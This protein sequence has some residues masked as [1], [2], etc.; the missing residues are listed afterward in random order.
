MAAAKIPN[1]RLKIIAD[2]N[3]SSSTLNILP[4]PWSS[5]TEAAELASSHIAIAPLRNDNWSKG[6]CALKV[7]QY[8]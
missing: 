8:I 1:L 4:I 6:K 2:F 5:E 3:L 7:L